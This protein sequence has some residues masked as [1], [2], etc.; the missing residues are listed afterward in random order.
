VATEGNSTEETHRAVFR[1]SHGWERDVSLT[2]ILFIISCDIRLI[3]SSLLW[4]EVV[5]LLFTYRRLRVAL[6]STVICRAIDMPLSVIHMCLVRSYRWLLDEEYVKLSRLCVIYEGLHG[7]SMH[8]RAKCSWQI[9]LT[10]VK[11]TMMSCTSLFLATTSRL[12]QHKR[13]QTCP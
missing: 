11:T 5:S 6:L 9:L 8:P 1:F 12:S 13:M 7:C 10:P 2:H 4:C 3:T